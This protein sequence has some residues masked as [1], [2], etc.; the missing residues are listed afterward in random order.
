MT[1]AYPLRWPPGW[2]RHQARDEALEKISA[3]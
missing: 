3:A 1:E 2:P